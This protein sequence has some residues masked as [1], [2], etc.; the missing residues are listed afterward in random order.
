MKSYVEFVNNMTKEQREKANK[1]FEEIF[2]PYK[3]HQP[4]ICISR[5]KDDVK[6]VRK[7]KL[8]KKH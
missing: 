5:N 2:A 7:I 1:L 6:Y 8:D 3:D 4:L